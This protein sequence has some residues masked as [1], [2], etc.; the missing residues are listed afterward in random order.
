MSLQLKVT[1]SHLGPFRTEIILVF[2]LAAS[3]KTLSSFF[4]LYVF[5][6]GEKLKPTFNFLLKFS[7]LGDYDNLFH[8]K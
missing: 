4:A 2:S 8:K 3:A 5:T 1:E 7:C 6:N